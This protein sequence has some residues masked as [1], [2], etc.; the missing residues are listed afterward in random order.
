MSFG[1]GVLGKCGCGSVSSWGDSWSAVTDLLPFK[2]EGIEKTIEKIEN[3]SLQGVGG[4]IK[5]DQ[6]LIR[7]GGDLPGHLDYANWGK[8]LEA[9]LGS[10]AAGVYSIQD[11]NAK[12]IRLEFEKSISRWRLGSVKIE[13]LRIRGIKDGEVE[14]NTNLIVQDI[15]RSAT[16][17]PAIS[18]SN[19]S[20]VLF[21]DGTFRVGDNANALGSGD[22][23]GLEEFELILKRGFK[24]DDFTN[25]AQTVLVPVENG[26]REASLR[27]K[28]PRYESDAWTDWK[29]A[30]TD[31]QGDLS[32]TDGS[33]TFLIQLPQMLIF[34]GFDNPVSG[35]GII[36]QEGTLQCYRRTDNSYMSVD[37]EFKITIS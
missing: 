18:I 20:R 36:P 11:T 8:V 27:I 33:N 21:N 32:F 9:A 24:E 25:E 19:H 10:V 16:A 3:M 2:S 28:L 29:D 1:S 31:L 5:A 23:I 12:I 4:K 34:E 30:A 14:I 6:G 26:F 35:P 15:A 17:F 7:V 37:E 22:A 13:E